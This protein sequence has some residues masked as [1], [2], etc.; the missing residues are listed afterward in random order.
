MLATRS[1]L[2]ASV[3]S[4]PRWTG[5]THASSPVVPHRPLLPLHPH[6]SSSPSP[7][8]HPPRPPLTPLPPGFERSLHATPAAWPKTLAEGTGRLSRESH[9]FRTT[10]AKDKESKEE[11]NAR[12][13]A[14]KDACID[15]RL[16]ANHWSLE[17]GVKAGQIGQWLAAERW[18]RTQ[19]VEGGLTLVLTHACGLQK[20]VNS[21]LY[22]PLIR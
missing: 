2:S 9:P 12:I 3:T 4:Y 13:V 5:S 19:P 20:E 6:P 21:P 17:D 22:T 1:R 7:P 14:E 15:L 18:R 8:A 11:R 10:P 16:G